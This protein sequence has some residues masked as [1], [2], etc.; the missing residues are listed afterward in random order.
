MWGGNVFQNVKNLTNNLS[1]AAANLLDPDAE[2]EDATGMHN[3]SDWDADRN[4]R[5][6]SALNENGDIA[7]SSYD[8]QS[9]GPTKAHVHSQM[10]GLATTGL[11]V[12]SSATSM[13]SKVANH[14]AGG[15]DMD[16]SAEGVGSGASRSHIETLKGQVITCTKENDLLSTKVIQL[17]RQLKD[18]QD[19]MEQVRANESNV[20]LLR[21]ELT[22]EQ[23]A[24][25][26][27]EGRVRHLEEEL[28]QVSESRDSLIAE[29]DSFWIQELDVQRREVQAQ[30]DK[31][32]ELQNQLHLTSMPSITASDQIKEHQNQLHL[33]SMPSIT[34]SDQEKG[35]LHACG[36]GHDVAVELEEKLRRSQARISELED[37]ERGLRC[38]VENLEAH[39]Q[40]V[41]LD[42]SS[43]SQVSLELAESLSRAE[44]ECHELKRRLCEEKEEERKR[45]AAAEAIAAS[46]EEKMASLSEELRGLHAQHELLKQLN[47]QLQMTLVERE[48][49][50]E[51]LRQQLL[52]ASH[53]RGCSDNAGENAATEITDIPLGA[54]RSRGVDQFKSVVSSSLV[55][56]DNLHAG[57]S[58][59]DWMQ[60]EH[61]LKV[62]L[63]ALEV[64]KV[65]NAAMME[66]M[67]ALK[68]Q[69][70]DSGAREQ[71]SMLK[72]LYEEEREYSLTSRQ[73][74]EE[75]TKARVEAENKVLALE[76]KLLDL[77]AQLTIYSKSK[78]ESSPLA[79]S[80]AS[81]SGKEETER[82][83]LEREVRLLQGR[84][85][86]QL[87]EL[88][89]ARATATAATAELQVL[90]TEK[91]ALSSVSVVSASAQLV[92]E[93]KARQAVALQAMQLKQQ[94]TE[95]HAEEVQQLQAQIEALQ[96]QAADD[97]E[98]LQGMKQEFAA[99][100]LEKEEVM[101]VVESLR[102]DA[103]QQSEVLE[104]RL[105]L[106]CIRSKELVSELDVV[107]TRLDVTS[108]EL[109]ATV[110]E[111]GGL[112]VEAEALHSQERM[113]CKLLEAQ[114]KQLSGQVGVL[115]EQV[116]EQQHQKEQQEQQTS[117]W[118]AEAEE[119]GRRLEVLQENV[120]TEKEKASLALRE[121]DTFWK[122]E[123]ASRAAA[124]S[125][126][127]LRYKQA[128][129]S[130]QQQQQRYLLLQEEVQKMQHQL[131]AVHQE[132]AARG[133]AENVLQSELEHTQAALERAQ[134][135]AAAVG[136]DADIEREASGL[137]AE[138]ARLQAELRRVSA[139]VDELEVQ[140]V[141]SE[142]ARLAAATDREAMEYRCKELM[143]KLAVAVAEEAAAVAAAAAKADSGVSDKAAQVA[144]VQQ[145]LLAAAEVASLKEQLEGSER[146]REKLKL[147]LIRLKEQMM[148]EQDE[149]EDKLGWRMEAEVQRLQAEALEQ[150]TKA[151]AAIE[152]LQQRH[153]M[154]V[155]AVREEASAARAALIRA[156]QAAES[157]E[158]VLGAKERE[159][160][161]LQAALGEMSYESDAAERLRLEVRALT[162][163]V[164]QYQTELQDAKH[165]A[166]EAIAARSQAESTASAARAEAE[167][168][169]TAEARTGEEC[170]M[171]R[172][173]LD[174]ALAQMQALSSES[175]SHV[176]RRIVGKL[177]VTYFEKKSSKEVLRLLASMLGLS[178][179]EK[180][181]I[182]VVEGVARRGL[183]GSIAGVPFSIVQGAGRMLVAGG[184]QGSEAVMQ[185]SS[186]ISR[187]LGDSNEGLAD[188]WVRFLMSQAERDLEQ[189]QHQQ[190]LGLPSGHLATSQHSQ[191]AQ[192]TAAGVRQGNMGPSHS[193]HYPGAGGNV[194]PPAMHDNGGYKALHPSIGFMPSS[195]ASLTPDKSSKGYTSA[196]HGR[197]E[198][199][200]M[201]PVITKSVTSREP[202]TYNYNGSSLNVH[203]GLGDQG[204]ES[205]GYQASVGT[206]NRAEMYNISLS[207]GQPLTDHKALLELPSTVVGLKSESFLGSG[208]AAPSFLR[209]G[210]LS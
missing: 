181:R 193:P 162:T 165:A 155:A 133:H 132:L 136:S 51:Q 190:Q 77:E 71:L 45:A 4:G 180:R 188:Q 170:S 195:S 64:E 9:S 22:K 62:T 118:K 52:V 2:E 138:V 10:H 78:E 25:K 68:M 83:H 101:K 122:R 67:E 105:R 5:H 199:Y 33:T 80:D 24:R 176:D 16:S 82:V 166:Q 57:H 41:R 86:D 40:S 37:L 88:Q 30:R 153:A 46:S 131:D 120:S 179:E 97:H 147:Q 23:E 69:G 102:A 1:N 96:K 139:R 156:Q 17:S 169:R 157:W 117:S 6:A 12:L 164:Q 75:Q 128:A 28:K 74:L 185:G 63:T 108:R 38:E 152:Q 210:T 135:Q 87:E 202:A 173:A 167:H 134:A 47:S 113:R 116:R 43:Q 200:P 126:V 143:E 65:S 36:V 206:A 94:E 125:D 209:S 11:G 93:A 66:E 184:G 137:R 39:L 110:K 29:R 99:L 59:K 114:V 103:Q 160:A 32:K 44:A 18:Q 42:L 27:A 187:P 149:E 90:R 56:E 98:Q 31:I 95:A 183:L 104:E 107:K 50:T 54:S 8:H 201:L 163:R 115:E 53:P 35:G 161:N 171:L 130:A 48:Q 197:N 192:G 85:A 92:E 55:E 79:P 182:G 129:D 207:Q 89:M 208:S 194:L 60:L 91:A 111:R 124:M 148:Q 204:Q 154:E 26:G 20:M 142:G 121:R 72:E 70:D 144:A 198:L 7:A 3:D 81:V 196:H 19:L 205:T 127:E 174:Q 73:Q 58:E 178:E 189:Q 14:V 15:S 150:Q 177:L 109:E 100:S 84:L 159:V 21:Q 151:D 146:E 141:D 76:K 140:L 203:G 123:I 145:E 112:K 13:L 158:E 191:N 172:R 34:A 186:L 119:V 168:R 175:C 49:Q 61:E 106:E